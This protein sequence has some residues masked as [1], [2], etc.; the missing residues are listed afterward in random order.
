MSASGRNDPCPCGSG[1]KY[2]RCCF[3]REAAAASTND[4]TG[5]ERDSA[6]AAVGD[7]VS[8]PEFA[9]DLEAAEAAF[10]EPTESVPGAESPEVLEES[11][12]FFEDWLLCD[13]QLRPGR[14]AV[15]LYLDRERSRLKSARPKLISLL[16]HM[17]S[18]SEHQRREGRPA[19][20]FGWMWGELGLD[21]PQ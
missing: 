20:D 8:R 16:K 12:P 15:D 1:R 9:A 6:W 7:Y 2:K 3:L 4:Y 17:E 11:V 19:Y 5:A 10:F 18:M 13:F 21:R 14:T